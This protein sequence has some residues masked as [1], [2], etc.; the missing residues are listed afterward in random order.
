M[1]KYHAILFILLVQFSCRA[2][3]LIGSSNK[4]LSGQWLLEINSNDIGQAKTFMAFEADS[5]QFLAYTRKGVDRE[6]M[7]FATSTLARWF[8]NSFEGGS[9]LRIVNGKIRYSG[10][11]TILSGIFTSSIGNYYFNGFI[12]KG[13]LNARLTDGKSNPRGTIR[14]SK[15]TDAD[16]LEDYP[17]ITAKALE[18]AKQKLYSPDIAESNTWRK[19]ESKMTESVRK[20]HDDL[21]L[22]FPFFYYGRK[23]G[24]SHFALMKIADDT[25]ASQTPQKYL[26]LAEP[27]PG[28]AVLTI[29]SFGGT[30][31]EVDSV[32][33][34]IKSRGY[35]NLVVDL[36]DNSGGSVEAG[37]RFA[38]Y[39]VDTGFYGGV[40]LTQKWFRENESL[41]AV[42]DYPKLTQFSEASYKLILEGI[43]NE[44][45]LCLSVKPAADTYKGNVF[46]LTNGATAS[47]CEPIV[48]GLKQH[49]LAT[50]VGEKTAGA[51]LN[52][53]YF[54]V[55]SGFTLIVPTADYYASDG[56]HI[57]QQGVKPNI[58]V[59][60]AEALNYVLDNLIH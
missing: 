22:I 42:S 19:F 29:S 52:G 2:N 27:K 1:A 17:T 15:N 8:T 37:L 28:T 60:S 13:Q 21:E 9:L 33:G 24:F 20:A 58:E 48:Y 12:L 4:Q 40:F 38:S 11:S 6:I 50:I 7:G 3:E 43:A 31:Q 57:D 25:T 30:A 41:P 26:S 47:T 45:G 10:D 56:Y 16:P 35:K 44:K 59:K 34:V 55:D 36:R 14:G 54:D 46:I 39:V 23:L 18:I 51:M 5:A 49:G 53:E 32:F